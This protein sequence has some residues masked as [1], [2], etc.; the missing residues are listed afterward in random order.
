MLPPAAGFSNAKDADA[1]LDRLLATFNYNK[2]DFSGAIVMNKK[3]VFINYP[4]WKQKF[5][6]KK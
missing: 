5:S 6:E 2:M 1:F 3:S 4:Y